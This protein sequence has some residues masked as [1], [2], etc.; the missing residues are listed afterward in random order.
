MK[1]N[2]GNYTQFGASENCL[3]RVT[4]EATSVKSIKVPRGNRGDDCK[5]PNAENNYTRS[6]SLH[7]T[8]GKFILFLQLLKMF[9]LNFLSL[10]L[11]SRVLYTS[12]FNSESIALGNAFPLFSK[13][14]VLTEIIALTLQMLHSCKILCHIFFACKP[15]S[16]SPW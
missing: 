8:S 1:P 5:C 3:C 4:Q 11:F 16:L 13:F 6:V 12:T 7:A 10:M 14:F 15:V 9:L 2:T